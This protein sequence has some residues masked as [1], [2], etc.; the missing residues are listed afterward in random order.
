MKSIHLTLLVL[1]ISS[2]G[3]GSFVQAQSEMAKKESK[4]YQIVDVPIPD[5]IQLEVGGL[6][7]TDDDKLGVSTR[8]GEVWVIDKPYS[9]NP[10]YQRFAHGLH[11]PLGLN[12]RDA[13]FYLSQRGEL[14][15]LQDKNGDGKADSYK[16][17]YSW[18]LSGNYHDYSYGPKFKKNGN[19]LVTLN[20]SWIGHGASLSKW[21]GWLL[22]ITPE[23][24]MTP[25]ATGLRSPS[26]FEINAEGDVFYTE[27]Q[28]DWVGS[29]RMT[30]LEKGDFAGN[31]E[32]L[33]WTGEPNAPLDLKM[34][35]IERESDL[36]LY[37]YAKQLP[38]MKAPAIWFP[39]TILGISTSDILYDTTNGAFGPFE[40]QLFIG[41]QGHSKIM[42]VYMEKVNGV[43]QGAAFNFVE[44]FS[45]GILRMIWGSENSMFVGMT[46]RGWSSTGKELFG[47]QRLRWNG[48]V[49]FEIKSMKAKADGFELEFTKPVN[50]KIAADP[51]SYHIASFNYKYHFK[52]GSP[53]V[54]QQSGKVAKVD[55][56]SDGTTA[57]LTVHGMRLGYIHQ[58]KAPALRS[59]TGEALLHDTGYYT[60]NEVP[61]GELKSPPTERM[62]SGVKGVKQEKRVN[63]IPIT[64]TNGVDKQV[65]IGTKP[66]LKYD[67]EELELE[68]GQKIELTFNN[69]DDMMHNLVITDRGTESVDKVAD[70][71][72]KLGLDGQDLN[73][74]P[75]SDLILA[76]TGILEPGTDEKIYF[77]TPRK[78]GEYWIVC[79][80]PGH[81]ASMRIKLTV[82]ASA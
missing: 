43:Y 76:H 53:V 34:E 58:L 15:R 54:D 65:V 17:I 35:D 13:S 2:G 69:D 38:A 8:R 39:H 61:G 16:T 68:S 20:L 14:T 80:F 56:S 3:I 22:E 41:D 36:S 26:G 62:A 75:E 72:L 5:E 6:A 67:I 74:V 79:T 10:V 24:E 45:S 21:R 19:M 57:K 4:Y 46:S 18:P 77:E 40:G 42:R 7:L 66:G 29:G 59:Q 11:E 82:K 32:G 70:M 28:G 37:E 55:V 73:F 47:L 63:E 27:N 51:A 71:A 78:P 48:K 49:P 31:P 23:G 60:L 30:H 50:K 52:Y 12:Y 81:A 25:I 44:G 9:K 1:L 64:W 33:V